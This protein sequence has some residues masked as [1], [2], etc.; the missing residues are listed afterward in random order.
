MVRKIH[1]LVTAIVLGAC[2]FPTVFST[3]YPPTDTALPPAEH[4]VEEVPCAWVWASKQ[5][6]D[7]TSQLQERLE[8]AGLTH[9]TGDV[10]VFGEDCIDPQ[11]NKSDQR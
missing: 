8:S 4:F 9:V 5:S 2:K 1:C 7:L 3:P 6:P 10:S 11:E